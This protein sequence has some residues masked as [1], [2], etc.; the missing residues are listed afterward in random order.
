M[1][2]RP[3]GYEPDELPDCSTPQVLLYPKRGGLSTVF[4]IIWEKTSRAAGETKKTAA[5][6]MKIIPENGG[7]CPY[8]FE[9]N[10]KKSL[11]KWNL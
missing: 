9:K 7:F 2:Q 3:S 4:F 8:I 6:Q 5:G 11:V 10:W 1:N